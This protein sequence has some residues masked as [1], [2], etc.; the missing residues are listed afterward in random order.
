MTDVDGAAQVSN[1]MPVKG[2]AVEGVA[3][4]A[5]LGAGGADGC[6]TDGAGPA[7][8]VWSA[9]ALASTW[10]TV[11]GSEAHEASSSTPWSGNTACLT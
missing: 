2:V 5:D 6:P 10:S 3:D 8:D 9:D 4:G 7:G 1:P 11:V